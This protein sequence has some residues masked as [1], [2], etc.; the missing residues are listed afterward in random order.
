MQQRRRFDRT[1]AGAEISAQQ[2][3]GRERRT[4]CADRLRLETLCIDAQRALQLELGIHPRE[5]RR[6]R[7]YE[8]IS[9]SSKVR[10]DAVGTFEV[11]KDVH[12]DQT[13]PDIRLRS[14]LRAHASR[15]PTRF[16]R[17][18]QTLGLEQNDAPSG[19][20]FDEALGN[21]GADNSGADDRCI[22]GRPHAAATPA[23]G[24]L[25]SACRPCAAIGSQAPPLLATRKTDDFEPGIE[26]AC[27]RPR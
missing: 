13:E 21:R 20:T 14:E 27:D 15:G 5:P 10:I 16:T 11:L 18:G 19:S 25:S 2:I 22:D 17:S 9:V 1:V 8:K 26:T 4:T 6:V 23:R 24:A 3:T 7:G 12:A